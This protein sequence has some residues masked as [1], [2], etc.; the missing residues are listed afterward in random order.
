MFAWNPSD[1]ATGYRLYSGLTSGVYDTVREMGPATSA[2]VV[3]LTPGVMYYFVV[4]AYNSG[5]ESGYSNE[6][7][8][9]LDAVPPVEPTPPVVVIGQPVDGATVTRKSLVTIQVEASDAREVVRIEVYV[10]GVL[11]CMNGT[12]E[13]ACTWDVPAPPRRVYILEARA[14]NR[15]DRWAVSPP[16]TV[17]SSQ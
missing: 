3:D 4:S 7:T 5:G 12:I 15:A 11:L 9:V 6:V 16:V 2:S 13:Y 1:R 8:V 17:T 14:V 10:N